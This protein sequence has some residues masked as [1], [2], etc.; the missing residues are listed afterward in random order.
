MELDAIR[1]EALGAIQVAADDAA[2]QELRVR[3]LG[4]KSPLTAAL[5][6]LG[7]LPKDERAALGAATNRLK[8][9]LEAALDG[10]AQELRQS[11]EGAIADTEWFDLS[12][13]ARQPRPGH[14][15]PIPQYCNH[16]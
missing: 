2:L 14:L 6:G 10:R 11:H 8:Q 1:T 12:M 15:H 4:R 3:F 7:K 16:P 5:R 13:P 9:E